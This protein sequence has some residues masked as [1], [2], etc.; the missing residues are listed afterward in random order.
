MKSGISR[1]VHTYHLIQ[2]YFQKCNFKIFNLIN[3]Y[4]LIFFT[5]LFSF[6]IVK[7]LTFILQIYHRHY[8]RLIC[9]YRQNF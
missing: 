3:F 5:Y 7:E 6:I 9:V 4:N 2:L 1:K 8:N